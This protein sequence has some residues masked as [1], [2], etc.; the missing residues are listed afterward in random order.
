[1][2]R[3]KNLTTLEYKSLLPIFLMSPQ[4][5][6]FVR[7]ASTEPDSFLSS[8][9]TRCWEKYIKIFHIWSL[10]M[11]FSIFY[12]DSKSRHADLTSVHTSNLNELDLLTCIEHSKY[13]LHT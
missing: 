1:M 2:S 8:V 10:F 4:L 6:H 5:S 9:P 7:N 13:T 3:K 12:H 11:C